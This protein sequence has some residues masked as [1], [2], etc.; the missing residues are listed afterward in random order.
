MATE[1]FG[2][3]GVNRQARPQ[4]TRG[5]KDY[6]R[7]S[8]HKSTAPELPSGPRHIALELGDEALG[9]NED[10]HEFRR[11]RGSVRL[12]AETTQRSE[13]RRHGRQKN[14]PDPF[15]FQ[16][17]LPQEPQRGAALRSNDRYRAHTR[18]VVQ[19]GFT[20]VT[21]GQRM[22]R[23]VKRQSI[24]ATSIAMADPG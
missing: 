5:V 2:V 20:R 19:T 14:V 12:A 21:A 24:S 16:A 11:P 13:G 6:V 17:P 8:H 22:P 3:R 7:A 1:C 10:V 18:L 15:D 9:G 23:R 4:A